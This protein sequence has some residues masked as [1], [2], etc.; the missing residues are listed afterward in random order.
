MRCLVP[1]VL[2][3]G[4]LG[5]SIIPSEALPPVTAPAVSDA[6][7]LALIPVDASWSY[8]NRSPIPIVRSSRP[9]PQSH[10][11]VRYNAIASTQLD[12]SGRVRSGAVFP[13]SSII[14]KALSNGGAVETY[15]VMM[16]LRGSA[17]AGYGG[18]IWAEFGPDG[19]VKYSTAGRG[20]SCAPCHSTG[21]DYTRMNDSRP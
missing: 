5:C 9:H 2:A 15:A 14:V 19:A 11:L 12:A 13:D 21:I 4:A 3:L 20:A 18:W 17:S 7:L 8:F 10:A 6:A 1:V 16:R